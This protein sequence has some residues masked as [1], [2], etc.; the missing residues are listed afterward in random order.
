MS[1]SVCL[2]F[3][4]WVPSEDELL[5]TSFKLE[6]KYCFLHKSI[7]SCYWS[8]SLKICCFQFDW[9]MTVLVAMQ[10]FICVPRQ[11]RTIFSF[12]YSSVKD[13]FQLLLGRKHLLMLQH[14]VVWRY[15]CHLICNNATSTSALNA[16]RHVYLRFRPFKMGLY[17]CSLSIS[18]AFFFFIPCLISWSTNIDHYFDSF[19]LDHLFFS[20]LLLLQIPRNYVVLESNCIA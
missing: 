16:D 13:E 6:L 20:L 10:Q 17:Y 18:L 19:L 9:F 2:L 7:L 3:I 5:L 12:V 15:I 11:D 14:T 1:Q 8:E 4:A